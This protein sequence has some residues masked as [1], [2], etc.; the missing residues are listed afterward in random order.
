MRMGSWERSGLRRAAM[1]SL[2][3]LGCGDNGTGTASAG[4]SSTGS[5]GVAASTGEVS[6]ASGPGST[7]ALPTTGG[8]VSASASS[9]GADPGTSTDAVSVT[10]PATSTGPGSTGTSADTSTGEVSTTSGSTSGG[11]ACNPPLSLCGGQC[12][13]LDVDLQHCGGCDQPC[14]AQ[15]QCNGGGCFDLACMPG[16]VSQCYSGPKE[17]LDVGACKA[18]SAQCN[19]EGTE[20][21]PCTGEVGP[22]LESCELP[23]DEN[24]DGKVNEGCY[25]KDCLAIKKAKPDAVDGNY[26]IDLDGDDGPLPPFMVQC[27]MTLDGGG[28]TRFNWLYKDYVGGEDPLGQ[29]LQDCKLADLQCRGRIP[30]GPVVDLMVKDLTDK[31]HAMWKFNNT[32]IS[33]AVLGALQ[34][35]KEYCAT[36]QVAFTPYFT[37]SSEAYCGSGQEGGCDSFFYT[38]GA[39]Q[40][41]GAWGMHFDGD[42][43]WCAA[44]FKMGATFGGCG[45]TGDQ[46]FLN[47]CDCDD[48]KG[49]LY[50]R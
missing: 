37:N 7:G 3:L 24:C 18:G 1:S 9:T 19:D 34:S 46:G 21:G 14:G 13:D 48:E 8:S 25:L 6:T 45:N 27:D 47:D 5:T 33:Q 39:C 32:V 26:T 40:N 44:A 2:L 23:G 43:A 28:W 29:A 38:S 36:N 16:A 15:Q 50:Y 4:G 22:A 41:L 42:G 17:T 30:A 31:Q 20:L 35:K 49:E 11:P 12:V 10:E